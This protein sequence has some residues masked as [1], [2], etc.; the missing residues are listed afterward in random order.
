MTD[1]LKELHELIL[2]LIPI[3]LGKAYDCTY[4]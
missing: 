4:K 2:Q 3:R 1:V